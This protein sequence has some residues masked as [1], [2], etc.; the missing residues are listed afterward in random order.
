MSETVTVK[1]FDPGTDWTSD[2]GKVKL[3]FYDCVFDRGGSD[4]KATWNK[5]QGTGDPPL[6]EQIDGEFYEKKPG[7]WRFRKASRPQG[8][9]SGSGGSF[10]AKSGG[11]SSD[12]TASIHRQVAL[13]VCAPRICSDG[14][15]SDVR[16]L[17]EEVEKFIAQASAVPP[18]SPAPQ[19]SEKQHVHELL[20]TLLEKA[21]EAGP[22][23]TLLTDWIVSTQEVEK[24][25]EALAAL[26]DDK[27]RAKCVAWARAGYEAKHGPLPAVDNS[28]DSI[29]F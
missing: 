18:A 22:I 13:K 6:N 14:L 3:T 12:E 16:S 9:G 17:V 10:N 11:K 8:G 4:F 29:P 25:D 24:Q 28:D 2:H 21:G 5:Q 1:S 23:A 26:Q 15:T 7:D 19:D 20:Y 27:R